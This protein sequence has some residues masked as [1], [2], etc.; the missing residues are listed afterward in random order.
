MKAT[1]LIFKVLL[2][3]V[4]LLSLAAALTLVWHIF[5]DPVYV[6]S[7]VVESQPS[8]AK[9]LVD[10]EE[11]KTTTP[12]IVYPVAYGWHTVK[13]E[14]AG[15]EPEIKKLFVPLFK[16]L[17]VVFKLT[18]P[19]AYLSISTQPVGADVFIDGKKLGVTPLDTSFKAEG[20]AV[21]IKLTKE[22]F[23]EINREVAFGAGA[24]ETL[25]FD[26]SPWRFAAVEGGDVVLAEA[27]GSHKQKITNHGQATGV[28]FILPDANKIVYL[29]SELQKSK[30]KGG[31]G[32]EKEEEHRENFL[33]A[34]SIDGGKESKLVD[35]SVAAVYKV[36]SKDLVAFSSSATKEDGQITDSFDLSVIDAGKEGSEK[37]SLFT[38]PRDDSPVN[39]VFSPDGN[40]VAAVSNSRTELLNLS[41]WQKKSL[42]TYPKVKQA[43]GYRLPHLSWSS[44]SDAVYLDPYFR[45]SLVDASDKKK[46]AQEYKDGNLNIYKVTLDGKKEL[47]YEAVV[48]DWPDEIGLTVSQDGGRLFL[49]AIRKDKRFPGL[50]VK[51]EDLV[52]IVY[53]P[54]DKSE[55]VVLPER[56][57][58]ERVE[59]TAWQDKELIIGT[60]N[61]KEINLYRLDLENKVSKKS[62]TFA[63]EVSRLKIFTP[64][65]KS[66]FFVNF[67]EG[68]PFDPNLPISGKLFSVDDR[69]QT[70]ISGE[71]N[72][73]ADF[74]F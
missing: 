25:N 41:N 69:Y 7:L 48:K 53:E 34:V 12:T 15:F 4:A 36:P 39:F 70:E 73:L 27:D 56:T 20:R 47:V 46:F 5:I 31:D 49:G 67:I 57:S 65:Y 10:G 23:R 37:Q 1:R 35:K 9:V 40:Y 8:D 6:G 3:L 38:T 16:V 11:V 32:K 59:L 44:D 72:S 18:Q 50:E 62:A 68:E 51:R 30:V 42:I 19:Y 60:N 52:P 17:P 24:K 14:K 61:R 54:A 66:K 22:G 33:Y 26:L 63:A 2:K 29:K 55:F 74:E 43:E 64:A 28:V 45:A 58:E 71:L 21:K 13:V